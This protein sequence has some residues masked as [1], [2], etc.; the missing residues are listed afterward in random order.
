MACISFIKYSIF[1][2]I[3]F[4]DM[5]GFFNGYLTVI[6]FYVIYWIDLKIYNT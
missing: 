4:K 6:E 3:Y 1:I 2:F 5:I